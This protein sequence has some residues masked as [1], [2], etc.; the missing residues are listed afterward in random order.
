MM[1][2]GGK[3]DYVDLNCSQNLRHETP[4][5]RIMHKSAKM[6]AVKSSKNILCKKKALP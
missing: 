2:E 4:D 3:D 6:V 1:V 5:D